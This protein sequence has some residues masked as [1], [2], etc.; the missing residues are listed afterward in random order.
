MAT[1]RIMHQGQRAK[2][3]RASSARA[4]DV[5]LWAR[6]ARHQLK[7]EQQHRG[8]ARGAAATPVF[9]ETIPL[10]VNTLCH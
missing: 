1:A 6:G 10:Q 7:G 9:H 2:S 5:R 4:P 8:H 3:G